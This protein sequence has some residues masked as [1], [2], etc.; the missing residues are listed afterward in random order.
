MRRVALTVLAAIPAGLA[1][2]VVT[3]SV[4]HVDRAFRWI[5]ALGAP[6]LVLA[7]ALGALARGRTAGAAGGAVALVTATGTWYALHVAGAGTGRVAP[8]AVAWAL[9]AIA[10]GSVFGFAGAHWRA[11]HAAP[12]ALLAGALAGEALVLAGEWPSHVART[13]LAAQLAFAAVVPFLLTRERRALPVVLALT[14]V[15]TVALGAAAE[16][17]R[18]LA[19]AAGWNGP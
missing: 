18:E 8:V 7:F 6:W 9:A 13:L 15:A 12:V 19:R 3:Q 17:L 10:C 11:G 14:L 5:G 4:D 16:E 2:G 1:L